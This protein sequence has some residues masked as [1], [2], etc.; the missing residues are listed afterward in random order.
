MCEICMTF[1]DLYFRFM[2]IDKHKTM[3]LNAQYCL[4]FT[5]FND[6]QF[7]AIFIGIVNLHAYLSEDLSTNLCD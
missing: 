6:L 5:T 3:A 7:D 2:T 4:Y 1:C